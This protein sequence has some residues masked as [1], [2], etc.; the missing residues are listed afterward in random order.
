MYV[1]NGRTKQNM[2]HYYR[3]YEDFI[4]NEERLTIKRAVANLKIPYLI[5]HGEKD[6]SVSISEAKKL[7]IWNPNSTLKTIENADHVF[8][9]KHPWEEKKL[10]QQLLEAIETICMWSISESNR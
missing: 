2:P 10:S 5:I 3:F 7:H 8:N 4:E 9:T 6:T 1:V